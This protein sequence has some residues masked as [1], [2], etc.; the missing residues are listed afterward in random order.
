MTRMQAIKLFFGGVREVT[1]AELI[2]LKAKDANG[3]SYLAM[4]GDG[5]LDALSVPAELREIS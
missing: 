1:N 3:Q 4:L 2:A 5:A